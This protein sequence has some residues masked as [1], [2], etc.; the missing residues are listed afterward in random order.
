VW[1]IVENIGFFALLISWVVWLAVQVPKYRKSSGERR[2]QLKW[3]YSGAAGCSAR[4]AWTHSRAASTARWCARRASAG[5]PGARPTTVRDD[6]AARFAA[7]QPGSGWRNQMV[8]I[9]RGAGRR[10]VRAG[11]GRAGHGGA[12]APSLTFPG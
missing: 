5:R 7:R 1:V 10:Y 6:S 8:T 3:L 4:A 2:L 9:L 11:A 12:P